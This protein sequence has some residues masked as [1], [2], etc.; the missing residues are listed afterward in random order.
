[1]IPLEGKCAGPRGHSSKA[2]PFLAGAMQAVLTPDLGASGFPSY[3]YFSFFV[4][5]G[6]IVACV[7]ALIASGSI[8]ISLRSFAPLH[9]RSRDNA[10][11]RLPPTL[12]ALRSRLASPGKSGG[13]GKRG[14]VAKPE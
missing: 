13:R 8:R 5:H 3:R 12:A 1:M 10:H 7:A 14:L 9:R 6:F 2:A 4:S 11:H